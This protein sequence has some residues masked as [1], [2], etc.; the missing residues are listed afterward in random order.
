MYRAP[1]PDD[2]GGEEWAFVAPY[3]PLTAGGALPRERSLRGAFQG[4]P[5]TRK[6]VPALHRGVDRSGIGLSKRKR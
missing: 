4:V 3:P 2:A 6:V 5:L 1:S